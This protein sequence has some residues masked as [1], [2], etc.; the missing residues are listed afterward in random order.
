[1]VGMTVA[2]LVSLA[3]AGSAI[4]FNAAQRQGVGA[5]GASLNT[6]NA[7]SMIKTEVALGGLGFFGDSAYRC[8]TLALGTNATVR[9]N[10]IA[11]TPLS[12]TRDTTT[13]DDTID[14]VYGDQIEAGAEVLLSQASDGTEARLRSLLPVTVGDAVVMASA[15]STQPCLVRTVTA[16][17]AS[18][19]T[20]P[21]ILT[22]ASTGLHNGATFTTAP[23]YAADDRVTLLGQLNW[24]RFRRDGNNLV[25]ELP[26]TGT[27]AEIG[28]NVIAL[29]AEYGVTPTATGTALSAWEPAA[30]ASAFA[31]LDGTELRRVRALRV[32]IVARSAQRE[33]PNASGV[34][35]ATLSMPDLFGQAVASDVADWSCYRYSVSTTVVPL[36]NLVMGY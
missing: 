9:A 2:L 10:G 20:T 36:R 28:R 15:T 27:Q 14:V 4:V 11:F 30:S 24:I 6:L 3:A 21:Q 19:A 25:A 5:S 8:S 13:G 1:M 17:T 7:L 29:R 22:F 33:K 35:Q 32:G 16:V 31:S 12:I 34:C 26:L 23:T 18:T